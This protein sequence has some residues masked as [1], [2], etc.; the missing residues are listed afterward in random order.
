MTNKTGFIERRKQKRFKGKERAF[1]T[2]NSDC[3]KKGQINDI[4]KD[5]LSFLYFGDGEES[6]GSAEIEIYSTN[7]DFYLRKLPVRIV[8]DVSQNS[9]DSFSSISTRKLAMRFE[10]LIPKQKILLN[11]FLKKYTNK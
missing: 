3:N 10:K 7:D 1:A 6:N 5:G 11:Y 8:S 9:N 4:S 2:L